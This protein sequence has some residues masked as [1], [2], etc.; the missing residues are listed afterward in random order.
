MINE[1][2]LSRLRQNLEAGVP[3]NLSM[4]GRVFGEEFWQLIVISI[5]GWTLK[6]D[7]D[8]VVIHIG[9]K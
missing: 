1:E 6:T 7:L 5:T 8:K 3:L 4:L 2:E 9:E